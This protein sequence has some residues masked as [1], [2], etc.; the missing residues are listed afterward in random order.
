MNDLTDNEKRDLINREVTLAYPKMLQDERRITSYNYKY[1][2]DLLSF[3]LEQFLTKKTLDYQFKVC[4]IDKALL[5]Y[6]G[7]SMSLNLKSK[8]SPYWTQVRKA[9]YNFRG[10]YEA[11]YENSP[12]KPIDFDPDELDE[13]FD[14]PINK[15]NPVECVA[16]AVEHLDYYHKAIINDYYF[17]NMTY[18]EMHKKYGITLINLKKAV[19]KGKQIIKEQCQH[20]NL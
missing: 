3:C 7:K 18:N 8:S 6:M 9:S 19:D 5:N 13:N 16:Y 4:C 10:V 11:E 12:Y 20:F 2:S 17:N 15:T 1:F 14:L